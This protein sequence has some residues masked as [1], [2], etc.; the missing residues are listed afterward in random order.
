MYNP[1]LN[2]TK[3]E[4]VVEEN[5]ITSNKFMGWNLKLH[6]HSSGRKADFTIYLK[7]NGDETSKI[8]VLLGEVV[9]KGNRNESLNQLLYYQICYARPCLSTDSEN[10]LLGVVIDFNEENF[11]CV[12]QKVRVSQWLSASVF[13]ITRDIYTVPTSNRS[14][15]IPYYDRFLQYVIQDFT[16]GLRNMIIPM[17][18]KLFSKQSPTI[19]SGLKRLTDDNELYCSTEIVSNQEIWTL[20][21]KRGDIDF[22][23]KNQSF[24]QHDSRKVIFKV[25]SCAF[26]GGE[27]TEESFSRVL[28]SAFEDSSKHDFLILMKELYLCLFKVKGNEWLVYSVMNYIEGISCNSDTFF[29]IWKNDL[30]L[31]NEFYTDVYKLSIEAAKLC[32]IF[33]FDIRPANIIFNRNGFGNLKNSFYIIDWD[34]SLFFASDGN[35]SFADRILFSQ[36]TSKIMNTCPISQI[37]SP[38]LNKQNIIIGVIFALSEKFLYCINE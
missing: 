28:N 9:F 27:C 31:R 38:E 33:H 34:S 23:A 2:K 22:L 19:N 4:L 29:S 14:E 6:G 26:S 3:F 20:L 37:L 18:D 30:K 5:T 12:M 16:N 15:A 7:R 1:F 13:T 35:S 17:L 24:D 21:C 32:K 11:V 10:V 25:S 36:C 8:P